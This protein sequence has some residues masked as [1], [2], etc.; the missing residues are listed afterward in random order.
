MYLSVG[1]PVEQSS[2]TVVPAI[3][4][5]LCNGF[6]THVRLKPLTAG[7]PLVPLANL[8]VGASAFPSRL[9]PPRLATT[10]RAC[11]NDPAHRLRGAV[12]G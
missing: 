5:H 8:G 3:L 2:Q 6:P 12:E 7:P 11:A 9:R 1:R 10:R 4:L